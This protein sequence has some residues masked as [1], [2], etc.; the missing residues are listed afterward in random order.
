MAITGHSTESQLRAY[1]NNNDETNIK[2]TKEQT[3]LFHAKSD[4]EKQQAKENPI[5]KVIKNVS[6]QN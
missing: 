2:R 6:T 4:F 3:D 5:M 1:I